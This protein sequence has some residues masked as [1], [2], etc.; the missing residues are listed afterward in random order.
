MATPQVRLSSQDRRQQILRVAQELFARQ[1]YQGTTT[2]Q[3]AEQAGVTEALIFRHFPS[4][5]D[6]YWTLL[7]EKCRAGGGQERLAELL[8]RSGRQS[9]E[10]IFAAVA[11]DILERRERDSDLVR[12]LLFSAL[13]NH[14]LSTRFFRTHVAE[15]YELLAE[16]IRAGIA[17]GRFRKMDPQ[18]A[19]RSFLGMVFYHYLVQDIFGGRRFREFDR[20]EVCATLA[21]IWLRGMVQDRVSGRNGRRVRNPKPASIVQ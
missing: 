18:L 12:L 16:Y 20:K 21:R 13:E 14:R 8:G 6:L 2:R 1:G 19:A 5:E 9:E 4:K 3:I 17:A 11:A 7:D 15:R 10:E